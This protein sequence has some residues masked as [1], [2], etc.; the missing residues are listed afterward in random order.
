MTQTSHLSSGPITSLDGTNG[1]I[2]ANASGEGAAGDL[3]EINSGSLSTVSAD[4]ALST[5]RLVRVPTN[6]KLKSLIFEAAAMSG[7]AFQLGLYYSDSVYDGTSAANQGKVVADQSSVSQVNLFSGDIDCSS[8]VT[9]TE[10]LGVTGTFL[11]TFAMENQPLWKAAN[12]VSDPGGYFDIVATCHS[13][14]V[15]TG[16]A[17][18]LSARYVDGA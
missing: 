10:E 1:V 17:M 5:Y 11:W 8:A 6:A 12:L 4:A 13:T 3:K 15:T 18:K 16:A 14:A 9:K 2:T 7:G